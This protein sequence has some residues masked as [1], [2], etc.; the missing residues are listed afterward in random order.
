MAALMKFEVRSRWTGGYKAHRLAWLYMTG[1]W[2][3][4]FIDHINGNRADNRY[5]NLR[6]ASRTENL[7]NSTVYRAGKDTP[8]GVRQVPGGKW[9]ARIQKNNQPIFLG[10]FDTADA[11]AAAYRTAAVNLFGDFAR[12]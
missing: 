7:A 4:G 10:R 3:T 5:A 2:P 6:S 8:K 1:E 9:T 12:A 11:A